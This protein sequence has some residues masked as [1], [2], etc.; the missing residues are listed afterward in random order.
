[1]LPISELT[2]GIKYP[3]E[4][5]MRVNTRFGATILLSLRTAEQTLM[6][7]FLPWRYCAAFTDEALDAINNG[8][9]FLRL[10]YEGKCGQSGTHR[11]AI[12]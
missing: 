11:L 5:A 6:K 4:V 3:I 8:A 9:L 2:V 7:V 1:M 12:M 10:I